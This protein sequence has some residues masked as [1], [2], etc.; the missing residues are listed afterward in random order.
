[1]KCLLS[2]IDTYLKVKQDRIRDVHAQSVTFDEVWFLFKPGNTVVRNDVRQAYRVMRVAT[3]RHRI[4]EHKDSS[5]SFFKD[6]SRVEFE[7]RQIFIKCV[8]ID[9]NGRLLGPV[10]DIFPIPY[11][12]GQKAIASLPIYPIEF[13]NEPEITK[14]SFVERGKLFAKAGGIEHMHY[15]G[16]TLPVQEGSKLRDEVDSQVVIDFEEALNRWPEWTPVVKRTILDE[17]DDEYSSDDEEEWMPRFRQTQSR[18]DWKCIPECC[19][20][21]TVHHD[22][23]IDDKTRT[24]YIASQANEASTSPSAAIEASA[25]S[26]LNDTL[27]DDDYLIMSFRVFGYVLRSRRWCMS[28]VLCIHCNKPVQKR[29]G[30]NPCAELHRSA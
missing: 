26:G 2:F 21:E 11:F 7:Q 9:F 19:S 3:T 18:S 24:D 8:H 23:S 4:K 29:E 17:Y 1:M 25:F 13:L 12:K 5:L 30:A 14:K 22:E 6:D 20:R 16:L 15:R 28:L 10:E 27:K